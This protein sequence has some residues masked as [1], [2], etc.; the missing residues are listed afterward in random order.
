[1]RS[2]LRRIDTSDDVRVDLEMIR[3][4]D[5][6]DW[7][8]GNSSVFLCLGLWCT[9]QL[10]QLSTVEYAAL[11]AHFVLGGTIPVPQTLPTKQ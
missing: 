5:A 11:I 2:E 1:M 7:R 4:V 3:N 6:A 9:L 8:F 10:A